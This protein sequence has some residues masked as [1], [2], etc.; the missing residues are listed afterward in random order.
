MQLDE[1]LARNLAH[2]LLSEQ[3]EAT[4]LEAAAVSVLPDTLP[5]VRRGILRELLGAH[6]RSGLA[7]WPDAGWIVDQLLRSRRFALAL[8]PIERGEHEWKVSLA[9]ACFAPLPRLA[10]L[11]VPHLA[12]PADLAEWLGV[13]IDQLDWMADARR[14]SAVTRIAIL[15]HYRFHIVPKRSGRPRLIEEPKPRLK[16]LQKRI[17]KGILEKLPV[18]EAAHGFVSGRSCL[19]AAA[20]HAGE[21]VVLTADLAD[22][23]ATTPVRRVHAIFRTLGYPQAVARLLTGL[24]TNV[25]PSSVLARVRRQSGRA[26]LSDAFGVRHLP[27]GAP[28]S[29]ALA[30]LAANALDRRLQG[31]AG[32]YGAAYTRYADDLAFSGG[33]GLRR[34]A[35]WFLWVV[36]EIARDEGYRLNVA[37]T[38]IASAGQRQRVTGIVVNRHTNVERDDFDRLKATLHNAVRE[39]PASQNREAHADFRAHLTGRVG[40]VEQV[41]PTRGAKL[42]RLLDQIGWD[43]G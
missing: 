42:R 21:S 35:D 17:L 29:P 16:A 19:D 8:A 43:Q 4:K 14:Q 18:H 31:L 41:N 15:Q 25:V 3:W 5:H 20:K 10:G 33:V 12:T 37:K 32:R 23:F 9:A 40:W 2:A 39:G 30:N 7:C 22:F 6:R 24:T 27:Q 36:A 11:A 13:S 26:G 1:I 38:R 34:N 28:T